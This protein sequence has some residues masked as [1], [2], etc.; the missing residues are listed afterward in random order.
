M[1]IRIIMT[2]LIDF[3]YITYIYSLCGVFI[4]HIPNIYINIRYFILLYYYFFFLLLFSTTTNLAN[5]TAGQVARLHTSTAWCL[6]LL[7]AG[8]LIQ[9]YRTQ[10]HKK[11][12][13]LQQTQTRAQL[14]GHRPPDPTFKN[15]VIV[16]FACLYK[17]NICEKEPSLPV[18]HTQQS[19]SRSHTQSLL[20]SVVL[21]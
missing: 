5:T 3:K 21:T 15:F 10:K 16:L 13:E 18:C 9:K 14:S 20:L 2:I 1:C 17:L 19:S 12:T 11:T 7:T 6:T 8:Q 4:Y